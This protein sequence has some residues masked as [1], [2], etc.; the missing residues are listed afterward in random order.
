MLA[1]YMH[2]QTSSQHWTHLGHSYLC[3]ACI[4]EFHLKKKDEE[5]DYSSKRWYGRLKDLKELR[6]LRGSSYEM[7]NKLL[8]NPVVKLIQSNYLQEK[9]MREGDDDE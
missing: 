8:N 2:H 4:S 3:R 7:A 9:L 6:E 5:D 1:C